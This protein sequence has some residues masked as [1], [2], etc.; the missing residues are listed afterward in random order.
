MLISGAAFSQQITKKETINKLLLGKTWKADYGMMNGMKIE[1]LGQMKSLEYTF[2]A[3][4]TYVLSPDRTGNWGYNAKNKNIEL[5]QGGVLRSVITT[6][7]SKQV[8]MILIPDKTAP[9][10]V[11]SLQIFFK[12]KA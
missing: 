5:F 6:L 8:V 12:P 4:K 3:D 10:G 7:N 9:K 2:K 11:K 1:K